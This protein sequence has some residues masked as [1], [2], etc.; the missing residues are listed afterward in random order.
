ML[1]PKPVV[2][3]AFVIVHIWYPVPEREYYVED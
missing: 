1:P 2:N 3:R